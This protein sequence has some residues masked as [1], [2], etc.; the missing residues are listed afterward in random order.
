[1]V[2]VMN[3]DG[4]DPVPLAWGKYANWSSNGEKILYTRPERGDI[5]IMNSNGCNKTPFIG[6]FNFLEGGE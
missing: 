2:W 5:W 3:A 1:M 4:N 6:D